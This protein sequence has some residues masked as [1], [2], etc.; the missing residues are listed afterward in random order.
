MK[1]FELIGFLDNIRSSYNVGSI[2]RTANGLG[3]R[4]LILAGITPT[5]EDEGI[6]KTALGTEESIAWKQVNNGYSEICKLKNDGYIVWGLENTPD[7]LDLHTLK[8]KVPQKP[9]VLVI[10]NEVCGIDPMVIKTCDQ[11]VAIPMQ[12][13]KSSFNVAIA[14]GIAASFLTY[15]QIFSQESVK[16]LPNTKLSP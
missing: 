8:D 15:C 2:F 4:K 13:D 11:V 16:K 6:S 14:F 5:P 3:I 9:L 1:N 10:G 12:G 7:A